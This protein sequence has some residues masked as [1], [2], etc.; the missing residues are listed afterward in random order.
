MQ[1][2]NYKKIGGQTLTSKIELEPIIEKLAEV[3]D[4]KFEG[5]SSFTTPTFEIPKNFT[6]GVICGPS[7]SGKSTLL[8]EFSNSFETSP[9]WDGN[10]AIASQLDPNLL[11]RLGLSS[12]PSLCRPYHVLS[13]GEKHRANIAKTLKEG[14]VIDEF[15]SVCNR[16]LAKS[17]SVGVRKT[18]DH[19]GYKNVVIATCHEDVINWLGP[20]WVANT[21]TGRLVEGRSERK[22]S[23]FRILPCS[24]KAWA[25]FSDHHYLSSEINKSAHCWIVINENNNICGFASSIAFPH[26]TLRNAWRGHRTVIL[27]DYQGM[28]LGGRVSDAIAK[29]FYDNGCLYFS[30]TAHPKLGEHRNK[31]SFWKPTS[32]NKVS[33]KKDYTKRVYKQSTNPSLKNKFSTE[34][35]LAH[36]DRVCYSHEYIGDG[37][38]A[39]KKQEV[40]HKEQDNFFGV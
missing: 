18:I 7:G 31:S 37:T 27:P 36:A 15:T 10:K 22:L 8:K 9:L 30:K 21:L 19:Y 16:D 1:L 24:V 6:L 4:Y 38:R 3:S 23:Q 40:K 20:D 29:M 13:T 17:I 34:I 32:K 2:F 35:Y 14:C 11:M 33:R 39:L 28:G 5:E 26:P 12:I 25:I